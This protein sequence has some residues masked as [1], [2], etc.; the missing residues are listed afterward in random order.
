MYIDASYYISLLSP[1]FYSNTMT[2]Q[3]PSLLHYCFQYPDARLRST[4]SNESMKLINAVKDGTLKQ[5]YIVCGEG[6]IIIRAKRTRKS[7]LN[8]FTLHTRYMR[9]SINTI[10][11]DEENMNS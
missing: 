8:E 5:E 11:R 4:Y 6:L 9:F 1:I 7:Y 2:S 3:V 10:R